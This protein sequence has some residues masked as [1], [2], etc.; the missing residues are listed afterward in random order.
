MTDHLLLDYLKTSPIFSRFDGYMFQV[1]E[2][3]LKFQQLEAG[4]VLFNEGESGNAISFVLVGS[5]AV[6]KKNPEGELMQV[7]SIRAGDSLGEMA[8]IDTLSRSATVKALEMT[9]I[10]SLEKK[11]FETLMN[12]YPRISV[13]ML[14]G[15]SIMLSLK[16]RRTSER[17]SQTNQ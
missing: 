6:L 8:I 16:L 17:L 2:P 5:L 13:E 4:E 7:G 9:A 10:V 15:I 12:D 14:R 3:Y 11:D 1:I